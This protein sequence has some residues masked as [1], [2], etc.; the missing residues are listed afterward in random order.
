[1]IYQKAKL[2]GKS[3]Q[4]DISHLPSGIYLSRIIS[5]GQNVFSQKVIKE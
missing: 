3:F 2:T 5:N 1:M 4:I